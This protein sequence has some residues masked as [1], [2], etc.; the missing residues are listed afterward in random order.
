MTELFTNF[1]TRRGF[2]ARSGALGAGVAVGGL[3]GA[4]GGDETQ[5]QDAETARGVS[6]A[7][8]AKGLKGDL[9]FL[10]PPFFPDEVK[11]QTARARKT[12]GSAN[13]ELTVKMRLYNWET[14]DTQI[15]AALSSPKPPDVIYMSDN[16]HL[17]YAE[18]GALLDLTPYVNA[19]EFAEDRKAVPEKFWEQLTFDGKIYGLP[20]IASMNTQMVNLDLI[21]GEE[22]GLEETRVSAAPWSWDQ[23]REAARR[24]TGGNKYGFA[25]MTVAADDDWQ[26][27]LVYLYANGGSVAGNGRPGI[28]SP[29][30]VETFDFL[31]TVVSKDGS[32]PRPGLY[33]RE[34]LK[35]LFQAGRLG[36]YHEHSPMLIFLAGETKL[37]FDWQARP[38]PA[39]PRGAPAGYAALGAMFLSAKSPAPHA[40][41]AYARYLTSGPAVT[42]LLRRFGSADLYPLRTDVTDSIWTDDSLVQTSSRQLFEDVFVPLTQGLPVIPKIRQFLQNM[43]SQYERLLAEDQTGADMARELAES[44]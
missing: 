43:G 29:N 15:T 14:R 41:F 9:M 20:Y 22:S 42:E 21:G 1:T 17:T 7:F 27:P 5:G 44:L 16:I 10:G 32:S 24:A 31:Q 35:G 23:L 30:A 12:L 18:Q 19:P 40:A 6:E 34:A 13:P 38:A 11:F 25:T 3:L 39:G 36:V 8:R 37:D 2:L 33:K 26:D 28:D 4:C